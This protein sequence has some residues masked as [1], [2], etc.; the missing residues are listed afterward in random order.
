MGKTRRWWQFSF[1]I[2]GEQQLARLTGRCFCSHTECW[3]L[4]APE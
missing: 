3:D 4:K 2:Q 1:G